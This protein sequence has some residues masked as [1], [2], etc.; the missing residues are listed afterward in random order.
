MHHHSCFVLFVSVPFHKV[1]ETEASN[2]KSF[3]KR[4]V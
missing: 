3:G 4:L 1:H 2:V